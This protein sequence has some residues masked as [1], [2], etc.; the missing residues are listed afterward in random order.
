MISKQS[1]AYNL[2]LAV[3]NAR[4]HQDVN[5]ILSSRTTQTNQLVISRRAKVNTVQSKELSLVLSTQLNY[6]L[7]FNFVFAVVLTI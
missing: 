7:G 1:M 2:M 4:R 6:D 3:I 5:L